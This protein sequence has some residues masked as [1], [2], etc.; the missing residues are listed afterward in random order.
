M[1]E[2]ESITSGDRRGKHNLLS[3]RGG[4]GGGGGG[5]GSGGGTSLLS[6]TNDPVKYTH[7]ASVSSDLS[8]CLS[9]NL[10]L[11]RAQGSASRALQC[12]TA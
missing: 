8:V 2:D 10:S 7:K 4:G 9:V 5:T 1:E 6:V 12:S 11:A 3:Q